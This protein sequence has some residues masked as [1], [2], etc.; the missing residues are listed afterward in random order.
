M[1]YWFRFKIPNGADGK[2]V[3]YSPGWH[4]TMPHCPKGVVVDLYNEV[5][6]F[7]IA[8]TEDTFVPKEVTPMTEVDAKAILAKTVDGPGIYS[9]ANVYNVWQLKEAE[10]QAI[11][12]STILEVVN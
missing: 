7:G 11:A 3:V 5:E 10:K 2:P 12:G 6:G 1:T 4:G 9:G 8:H